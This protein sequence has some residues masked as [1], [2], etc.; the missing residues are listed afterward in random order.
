MLSGLVTAFRTLTI[1]P[2]PGRE[3]SEQATALPFF[4][5]VGCVLGLLLWGVSLG[6]R[7]LS[8]NG[9]PGGIAILM[10]L[11]SCALTRGLHLDGLADFTDALGGG[12]DRQRRLAIMKDSQL[13]VFGAVALILVL[14]C[15]WV[16]F[17]RLIAAGSEAWLVLILTISRAMQVDL[18]VRLPYARAEGGTAGP[19]VRGAA[20]RHLF[21]SV[22]ITL[23]LAVGAYG[24]A[25]LGAFL[26]AISLSWLF[27]GWCRS[28]VGGVTGDL[29]GAANELEETLLLLLVAASSPRIMAFTGWGWITY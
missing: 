20:G 16:A 1:L 23:L 18:A 21:A 7:L 14:L 6:N 3:T 15:K 19:F 24:P 4:P 17:T 11:T 26:I 10:L 22:S 29:L 13:G 5:L 25:G 12:W 9:W 28:R 8:G 2:V 27:G